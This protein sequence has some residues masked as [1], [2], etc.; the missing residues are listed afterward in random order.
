MVAPVCRGPVVVAG[1]IVML[2]PVVVAIV[3]MNRLQRR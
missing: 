1:S 2:V 3:E